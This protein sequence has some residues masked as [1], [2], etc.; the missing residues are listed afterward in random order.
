[1]KDQERINVSLFHCDPNANNKLF[2]T[3]AV[4]IVEFSFSAHYYL[5]RYSFYG[6][7]DK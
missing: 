5:E 4:S 3:I 6:M 7:H 2:L 1:M